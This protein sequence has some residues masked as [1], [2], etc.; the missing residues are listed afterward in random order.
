MILLPAQPLL[1]L[2]YIII[3]TIVALWNLPEYAA[4]EEIATEVPLN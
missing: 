3:F 1:Q 4:I 2:G